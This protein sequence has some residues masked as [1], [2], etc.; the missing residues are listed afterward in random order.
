ML[1]VVPLATILPVNESTPDSHVSRRLEQLSSRLIDVTRRN[2]SIRLVRKTKAQC[3]DLNEA[4]PLRPGLCAD[5]LR[6]ILARKPVTLLSQRDCPID[7]RDDRYD[8]TID[9]DGEL[10]RNEKPDAKIARLWRKLESNLTHLNRTAEFFLNETGGMDLYLGYPWIAGNCQDADGTF[11]QAP[12][13]LLPVRLERER[14]PVLVWKLLPRE[15][16]EPIFNETL[17]LALEQ[18]QNS[19]LPEEFIERAEQLALNE[20]IA[21]S[22]ESLIDWFETELGN[23]GMRIAGIDAG[24]DE[25]PTYRAA[26]VPAA[27]PG[28][29]LRGHVVLG[30]FPQADSAIR[31]DYQQLIENANE[32]GL[33]PLLSRLLDSASD[34]PADG[35]GPISTDEVPE[36]STCFV[37]M[38]DCSQ[39]EAILRARRDPFLVVHGPPGTGKSQVIVNMISDALARGERVMLCCQK[40]AALDV[41]YQRLDQIGLSRNVAL[42]HDHAN[43]RGEVYRHIAR[44]LDTDDA[45]QPPAELDRSLDTLARDIDAATARLKTVAEE[46]HKPRRCGFTARQLYARIAI[47]GTGHRPQAVGESPLDLSAIAPSLDRNALERLRRSLD[48]LEKLHA[49]GGNYVRRWSGRE[50]FARLSFADQSRIDAALANCAQAGEKLAWAQGKAA[51]TRGADVPSASGGP[52]AL[53]CARLLEP[54]RALASSELPAADLPVA[55]VREH[56]TAAAEAI[57]NA[58][59][60]ALEKL[61]ALP[62]RPAPGTAEAGLDVAASLELYNEKRGSLFRIFN[63]RWRAARVVAQNWLAREALPDTPE[64]VAQQAALIRSYNEWERLD[65]ALAGQPLSEHV[66]GARDAEDLQQRCRAVAAAVAYVGQLRAHFVDGVEQLLG[67][68]KGATPLEVM[69]RRAGKLAAV[70]EAMSDLQ[71]SQAA[72]RPYMR[73]EMRGLLLERAD[74][75]GERYVKL[76]AALREGLQVFDTLQAIDDTL[77]RLSDEERAVWHALSKVEIPQGWADAV[78]SALLVAWLEEVE[79][80]SRELRAVSTG[81]IEQLRDRFGRQLELR[82][83]LNIERL[84]VQLFKRGT[85][86][87]FEPGREVDG[88]HSAEKPWRDLRH[89]VNKKRRLWPL[90]RMV[91]QLRWPLME[92]IPCWLVS[93]ETLSAAF[94]LEQG[95]FDMVIFDE[96]SQCPVQHGVPAIFRAKRVVIAGDEQQLRPFD[97][98]G[99][100]GSATEDDPEDYDAAA[101]EAESILTLAKARYPETMLTNHYRSRYEELIDFSNHGFYQGRLMTVPPADGHGSAP[102]EWRRVNGVWESQ[103]G[104]RYNT[105]E[106]DAVV[107]TI[108]ELL[109]RGDGKGIGVIAFNQTQQQR[110]LDR[111]DRRAQ[112]DPSFNALVEAAYHPADGDNEKALFVKNIE[113]VQGDQRDIIIFSIG[114]GPD[115]TGRV[116]AQFGSLNR[117]GGDNRLN[118]A[119]SRSKERIIVVSSVDPADLSVANAKNRGPRLLRS[120]LEYARAVSAR[121]EELRG[122]VLREVN[123]ARDVSG[124]R[125]VRFDSPFEEEVMNALQRQQLIVRTQVGVSGFRI[126]LAVVDPDDPTRFLLGIECDGATYHSAPSAR[127]RDVYRQRFLEFRGWHIHR[128][129]SRNWWRNPQREIEKVMRL[130]R[131]P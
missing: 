17:V 39:E 65:K 69:F 93:P 103:S 60:A 71:K 116:R 130:V 58:A 81:E 26:E 76:I 121:D 99:S 95:F 77:D 96:A 16:A 32:H 7:P 25:L 51:E 74:S 78:E 2:R 13:L 61:R 67:P 98:F 124:P 82:R 52:S 42:V 97:L 36:D 66:F 100:L 73:H 110:I 104:R 107:D 15:D 131:R 85:T 68:L 64:N 111:I 119:V 94:P 28:F 5:A 48:N 112:E 11:L 84:R 1:P 72:L 115:S 117:E 122:A 59:Y 44:A 45:P 50:S 40:R 54:L 33:P 41:V 91:S 34:G 108:Y 127:E 19:R 10:E 88:R 12:L 120:Y 35:N 123:P 20:E 47:Q 90:R 79:R 63:S 24:A 27:T 37:T 125:E 49:R 92:T 57:L 62:P 86:P 83:K 129:W 128:I 102:I 21:T 106:A 22:P 23:L 30:Y 43:D 46:L 14:T 114:Y 80:E 53:V 18:F 87:V 113:N 9:E 3:F 6:A 4:E 118:V 56:G 29:F 8:L 89:Q 126:D 75:D 31:H 55:A 101:V 70:G 105:I 109:K 38:T